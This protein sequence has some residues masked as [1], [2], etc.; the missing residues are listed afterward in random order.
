M[1]SVSVWH[2]GLKSP[3]AVQVP[4]TPLSAEQFKGVTGCSDIVAQITRLN[5]AVLTA[6]LFPRF[7]WPVAIF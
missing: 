4:H 1:F 5:I 6:M 7:V 3:V 2:W